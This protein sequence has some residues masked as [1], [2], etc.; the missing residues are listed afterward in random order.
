M[1]DLENSLLEFVR[2]VKAKEQVVAGTLHHLTLEVVDAGKK[3]LNHTNAAFQYPAVRSCVATTDLSRVASTASPI[4]VAAP[5]EKGHSWSPIYKT[6]SLQPHSQSHSHSP[7]SLSISS[8][9]LI[10]HFFLNL[11]ELSF[12]SL[13][14]SLLSLS[15]D[16]PKKLLCSKV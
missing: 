11:P 6:A 8:S 16:L 14:L 2:V 4:F 9:F 10:F 12:L 15:S 3:K 5:S 1:V 13:T 7:P